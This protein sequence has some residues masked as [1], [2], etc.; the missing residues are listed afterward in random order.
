MDKTGPTEYK[1]QQTFPLP[2]EREQHSPQTLRLGLTLGPSVAVGVGPSC[3]DPPRD[4][5]NMIGPYDD[6]GGLPSRLPLRNGGL[7]RTGCGVVATAGLS[8]S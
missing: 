5:E 1:H 4:P 8:H 6:S 2:D 3:L 7:P